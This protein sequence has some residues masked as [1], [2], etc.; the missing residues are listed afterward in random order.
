MVACLLFDMRF[1]PAGRAPGR[2][3]NVILGGGAEAFL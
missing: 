1:P 2:A 3:R